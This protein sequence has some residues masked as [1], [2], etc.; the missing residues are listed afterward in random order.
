[1]TGGILE[2]VAVHKEVKLGEWGITIIIIIQ[3]I[4]KFCTL[5]VCVSN[6]EWLIMSF[7]DDFLSYIRLYY[8]LPSAVIFTH[9][10]FGSYKYYFIYD[11]IKPFY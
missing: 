5:F 6:A 11:L 10:F 4:V 1:M 7:A 8:C 3:I 2:G 9:S